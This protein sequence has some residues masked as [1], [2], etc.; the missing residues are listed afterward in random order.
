VSLNISTFW[1]RLGT[2]TFTFGVVGDLKRV[3]THAEK[4]LLAE[5]SSVKFS[6]RGI[7]YLFIYLLFI[8]D[9]MELGSYGPLEKKKQI[10]CLERERTNNSK[11]MPSS[12]INKCK[13]QK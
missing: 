5:S 10:K 11:I 6:I 1:Q 8:H 9:G 7:Q 12:P 4:V 13:T 2:A 3:K